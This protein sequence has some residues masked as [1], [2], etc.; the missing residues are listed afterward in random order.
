MSIDVALD[1]PNKTVLLMGNEGIARGAIEAGVRVATGYPGTP[2]TEIIDTLAEVGPKFG[3]HVE[4]STNEHVA[5]EV[6]SGAA[7]CNARALCAM[8][9]N[10]LSVV[11][12]MLTHISLRDISGGLVIVSAG[13]PQLH[14]SQTGHDARWM[15]RTACIPIIEPSNPQE[16]KDFTKFAF[17]LSEKAKLPMMIR[18]VTR[19]SHMSGDVVLDEIPKRKK[20]SKFDFDKFSI[21][22][23]L[24]QGKLPS[25]FWNPVLHTRLH[26][27][28][29]GVKEEFEKFEGNELKLK[30]NE[31]FGIVASGVSYNYVAEA[32][33]ELGLNDKIAVLKLATSYPPPERKISR[34]LTAVERLL[35]VEEPDPF[36]EIHVRALAKDV[37]SDLKIY[38]KDSGHIPKEGEFSTEIVTNALAE[39]FGMEKPYEP[40]PE[41]KLFPRMLTM[42]AGCPHRAVGYAFKRAIKKVAGSYEGVI[43]DNDIGCYILLTMPPFSLNDMSFCMGTSVSVPQGRYHAGVEQIPV[44]FVGDSTFLH[45]GIPGLVNAVYNKAKT[46]LIIM[47][48][49]TTAMTGF[50]PHPGTGKTATGGETKLIDIAEIVKACG[51]DFV[52]VVDP[53]DY[54]RLYN[55]LIDMLKFDGTA[56][57]ISRR[58][59]VTEA[60][61]K[62]RKEGKKPALYRADPGK[63]VGC[64]ICTRQ[65]GCPAI[66]WKKEEKK[67]E[68]TTLCSGC[69]VCAQICP[70]EAISEVEDE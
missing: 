45:A 8:K 31:K 3:M 26:E 6:A 70:A 28:E 60:L 59:C 58:T 21:A 57:V 51:A 19:S 56:V 63:C 36:V 20:V 65:F 40:A 68:I 1:S 16:A 7:Q 37:N 4:W 38:G 62:M 2:S 24:R 33:E 18:T 11:C 53:Y 69:G 50:Q 29:Q 44:G 64:E 48:N 13:D 54:E 12:D 14:S 47:D 17:E 27:K 25:P 35:V 5:L 15:A 22:R 66:S 34:L 32:V 52:K 9:H 46:K 23:L 43:V 55:V 42:C 41:I 30:G 67:A 39:I 10:G 61:R 49:R